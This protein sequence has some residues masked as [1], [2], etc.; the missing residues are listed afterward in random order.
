M[1]VA[2]V[3]PL[4][5]AA[6]GHSSNG[7]SGSDTTI[8]PPPQNT[9]PYDAGLPAVGQ[10]TGVQTALPQLPTL[11]NVWALENDDSA[12]VMFDP[13]DGAKDYRVYPL[14]N[15]GDINVSAGGQ[16]VVHN[17]TY[18]CAGNRESPTPAIDNGP[19]P[20][21]SGVTTKVDNVMVGG[22]TRTLADA[23]LG[24]VY[25]QPGPG[26]IPVYALGESA[27]N[28][29]N[30]CYW[31][32][33]QASRLT[34]YTTSDA[35]R[36]QLLANLARDDGIAFYVPMTADSTTTQIYTDDSQV[37]TARYYFPD[38]PEAAAHSTKTPAFVV[39][40]KPAD[41]ALPLMR[42][43][44]AVNCGWSHDA[45][46]VGQERFNRIY[47]QG[48]AQPW[49]SVLWTGITEP[50]TLVVEALDSGCPWQGFMSP[51]S[52]PAFTTKTTN[53]MHQAYMTLDDIR[54][55]SSTTEVFINGQFDPPSQPK[56]VARSFVK[57][58]PN[59]HPKMDFFAAFSPKDAPET[60][61]SI[62]CGDP[63]GGC[64]QTWRQQ[65]PTFDQMFM[66]LD[67]GP[68]PGAGLYTYGQ[69][70]GEFWFAYADN[71]ADTNGKVRMTAR[72]KGT[73]D[74]G[75]F[76]HVTM[77]TD[78]YSTARRYPQILISDQEA[79]VQYALQNGHTLVLETIGEISPSNDWP[80]D[81]RLEICN[82]R[83]WDVNNQ[84]PGYDFY[85][86]KDS[87]GKTVN[88]APNDE[89]GEHGSVDHRVRFDLFTS[90]QRSYI[91]LDGRPYA[92]AILPSMG[93]PSGSVTVTWGDVLYHSGVDHTYAFHAAHMQREQRRHFD[94]L[95]F[96]SGGAAPTWDESRLP[97]AL[98]ISL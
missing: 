65:S 33:W 27:P 14:P 41:G 58:T 5:V 40:T 15:D 26:L 91:F 68:T 92:C 57:V 24:Y 66:I 11:T 23:T 6:C 38:G 83:T 2:C 36:S 88:L 85:H 62:P 51:Q 55:A 64:Y 79:P 18:R 3:W 80:I 9:I 12:E 35:E 75:T 89:V 1:V 32:R 43:F 21:G 8:P 31:A 63:G 54:A 46:A 97:C 34:K 49:W 71:G 77:E 70:L 25:T 59:P 45:L 78:D 60:Y 20:N 44:Y 47:K 19:N 82:L 53:I 10:V 69:M 13:V 17:G 7:P 86:I 29:D 61:T 67:D 93:I 73:M 48:D 42:V 81:Y 74:S 28:D 90:T 84:C 16:V 72:Q 94:N 30:T 37:F 76:L 39:R 22:Y 4:S 52:L 87:S 96:T 98:P 95:G 50:T 56:A